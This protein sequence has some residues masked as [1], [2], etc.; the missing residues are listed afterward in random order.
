MSSGPETY[1]PPTPQSSLPSPAFTTASSFGMS[2]TTMYSHATHGW[3]EMTSPTAPYPQSQPQQSSHRYA[4]SPASPS[5]AASPRRTS[6]MYLTSQS[7]H[8]YRA[9]SP[10]LRIQTQQNRPSCNAAT[11]EA[12]HPKATGK[13]SRSPGTTKIS[14]AAAT[15][16]STKAAP[17]AI[18]TSTSSSAATTTPTTTKERSPSGPFVC[19]WDDACQR[20]FARDYDRTRHMKTH[21]P[22][23]AKPRYDCPEAEYVPWCDRKGE[24][25]FSRLDH[26]HQH[27]RNVHMVPLPKKARGVR[28]G[29]KKEEK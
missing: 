12:D 14:A 23:E 1:N 16:S 5:Y 17:S 28:T 11:A 19:L 15:P 7:G 29:G 2:P 24:N 22:E 20:S 4:A 10:G 9:M 6:P 18:S 26:M 21:W 13:R 3:K 8:G 27:R 25:A